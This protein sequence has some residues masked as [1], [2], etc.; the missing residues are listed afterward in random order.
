M[1]QEGVTFQVRGDI[2]QVLP[3]SDKGCVYEMTGFLYVKVGIFV[4]FI[5][6]LSIL[7]TA[8]SKIKKERMNVTFF[9]FAGIPALMKSKFPYFVF[10]SP[11]LRLL[12]QIH[13]LFQAYL[14]RPAYIPVSF[15]MNRFVEGSLSPTNWK[16]KRKTVKHKKLS[17][18]QYFVKVEI[19][20]MGLGWKSCMWN[21]TFIQLV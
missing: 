5:F 19:F 3:D 4:I 10:F 1:E 12:V 11:F 14:F 20:K 18:L 13:T 6:K 21:L 15:F 2:L 8:T 9:A 7:Q 17:L 16:R